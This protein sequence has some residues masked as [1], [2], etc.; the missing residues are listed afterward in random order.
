VTETPFRRDNHYV[1]RSY[2]KRWASSHGRVR[3]YRTLVSHSSVPTWKES[4]I[5]KVAYRPHLYTRIAAGRESDEVEKWLDREVETPAEEAL[6]KAISGARLTPADWKR[7]VRFLAAQDVR[8]PARFSE[9]LSR[10][11]ATLPSLLENTLHE[12]VRALEWSR[13]TGKPIPEIEA[14]PHVDSPPI[15]VTTESVPGQQ[16]GKLKAEIV[17]GR[18]LWLYE[19][20]HLVTQT[21][22]ALHQHKWTILSPPADLRWFTSDDPVIRLNYYGPGKYDF[23]GGWGSPGTEIFFPL[24]P[25]HLLYTEVGKRPPLRG[26]R[27]ERDLAEM[28]RRFIAEHADRM[29]IAVEPNL[30]VPRLRPRIVNAALFRAEVEQ[31]RRWHEDQSAGE[32]ELMDR[33]QNEA[34]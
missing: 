28:L 8:T 4:S 19:I 13:K 16:F 5:C 30:D 34:N 2:L 15:R 21:A 7:L 20:R 17:V 1:S 33:V 14:P 25:H 29:I 10:W 18:S 9:S 27:L 3:T 26:E 12:S 24:S 31:W 22:A 6:Q 23:K 32:R 11:H